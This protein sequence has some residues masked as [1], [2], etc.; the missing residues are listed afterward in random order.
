M[1]PVWQRTHP[2]AIAA[3]YP[4]VP[5]PATSIMDAGKDA[6]I[7]RS[8]NLTLHFSARPGCNRIQAELLQ[9][10]NI[11][12]LPL[13]IALL[14]VAGIPAAFKFLQLKGTCRRCGEALPHKGFV[15][16]PWCERRCLVLRRG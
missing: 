3:R 5:A 11:L 8:K 15:K 2:I 4:K 14:V 6:E 13:L 7:T 1:L 9:L 12:W 10:I 16:C